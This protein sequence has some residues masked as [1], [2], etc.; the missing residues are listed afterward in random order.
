M[1][2]AQYFPQP[3][4]GQLARLVEVR[5]TAAV[6]FRTIMHEIGH[7][8]GWGTTSKPQPDDHER[9]GSE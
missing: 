1:A 3:G 9:R 4:P 5:S 6:Y 2:V 8:L 7:V